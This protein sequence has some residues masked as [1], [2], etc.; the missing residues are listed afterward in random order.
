MGKNHQCDFKKQKNKI[1][2]RQGQ[3]K[4]SKG[5]NR[6]LIEGNKISKGTSIKG[7][8]Q[9]DVA[10]Y[11][12]YVLNLPNMVR[13]FWKLPSFLQGENLKARIVVFIN[14]RGEVVNYKFVEKSG[15]EDFDNRAIKSINKSQPFPAPNQEIRDRLI[16][17]GVILGFP[18]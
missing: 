14:S 2:K 16:S 5:L 6:L 17:S 15:N 7:R 12:R 13:P 1:G 18:L 3:K 10:E 9:A 4:R 11:D 8:Y